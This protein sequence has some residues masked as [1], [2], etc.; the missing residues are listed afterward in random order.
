VDQHTRQFK[1]TGSEPDNL[2]KVEAYIL[3]AWGEAYRLPHG[4]R[5][6]AAPIGSLR[7]SLPRVMQRLPRWRRPPFY[8]YVNVDIVYMQ[9]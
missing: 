1:P 6:E 3:L 8:F 4:G 2:E 7:A 5:L 9:R